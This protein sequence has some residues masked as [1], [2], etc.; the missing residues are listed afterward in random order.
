M[1]VDELRQ[2]AAGASV[3]ATSAMRKDDVVV[4]RIAT[5]QR[6]RFARRG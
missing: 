3:Q 5:P 4:A 1:K 2:E 6:E